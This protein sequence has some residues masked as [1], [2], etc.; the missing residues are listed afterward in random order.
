MGKWLENIVKSDIFVAVISGVIVFIIS[1]I[2][3]EFCIKPKVEYNKLRGK[4]K[5]AIVYYADV[6]TNPFLVDEEKAETQFDFFKKSKYYE[7]SQALRS[8]ASEISAYTC[9]RKETRNICTLLIGL[10]NSMW[11]YKGT[12]V[13]KKSN[14]YTRL[15]QLKTILKIHEEE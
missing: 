13:D 10:S 6:T 8:L 12:P 14:N 3:L 7:A 11:R 5:V 9:K 15:N 1:Q 2:I 4:I